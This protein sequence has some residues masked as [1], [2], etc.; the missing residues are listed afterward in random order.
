MRDT[1][2]RDWHARRGA[3]ELAASWKF[4]GDRALLFRHGALVAAF[5][6]VTL[7]IRFGGKP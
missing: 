3:R 7:R 2:W 1:N 5:D 6:G 4:H